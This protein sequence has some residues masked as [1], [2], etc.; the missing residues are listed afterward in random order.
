[1]RK[2]LF[3]IHLTVGCL[4]GAVVFVMAVTG[5][6]LAYQHQ[7][8]AWADGD[9][10]STP[11]AAGSERLPMEAL[12]DE[13]QARNPGAP[14]AVTLRSDKAA[15]AEVSFG[16]DHVFLVDVYTGKVLGEVSPR[17]RSFFQSVENWHRWLGANNENRTTGRA[18]TGACNFGFL[19]LVVS[20]PFLWLPRK[21]SPQSVKAVALFRRGLSGRARDFNWHNVTGIWCAL[22][23]LVIV[24][25]GV[26]MSYP[27]ANNL[28]YQL[29]GSEL[30]VQGGGGQRHRDQ[31]AEGAPAP[32][33]AGP[34]AAWMR[35]EQQVP[36][37]RILTLRMTPNG[38]GPLVF[39][40][41]TGSGGRPDQRSQLTLDRKTGEVIRW[42]PFSSYNTG[43]RLRSW[44][45]FLHT[46]EAGGFAGETIAGIASAGA[47]LLTFT[48]L[49][50]AGRRWLRWR[51]R[52]AS[53]PELASVA[54]LETASK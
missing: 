1:M 8:I 51:K 4:A 27:W 48:G 6:L 52:G 2:I 23:L 20:G 32:S 53:T 36:G 35:A 5:V 54:P 33:L 44:L 39:T 31:P 40:I 34:S 19:L 16:R 50:L 26:V 49:W 47:A 11:A 18:V 14:T 15:P 7:I 42:E 37:W 28:L 41:D 38:R 3:W 13:V 30:P 10:H 9:L 21:L 24:L 46:G 22:P 12:L 17:A 25:S 43:R 29:T 45:R